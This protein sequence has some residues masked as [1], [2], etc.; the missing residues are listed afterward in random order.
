LLLF[1]VVVV[2]CSYSGDG[3]DG[4]ACD[5]TSVMYVFSSSTRFLPLWKVVE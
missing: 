1:K 4:G 2:L 5:D 3:G